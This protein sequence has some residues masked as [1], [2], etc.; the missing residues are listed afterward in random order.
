MVLRRA[1]VQFSWSLDFE[2]CVLRMHSKKWALV[3]EPGIFEVGI[4]WETVV[5]LL[6]LRTVVPTVRRTYYDIRIRGACTKNNMRFL[7]SN[8]SWFLGFLVSKFQ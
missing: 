4:F 1:S 6:D 3:S 7:G 5:A 2:V 8:V